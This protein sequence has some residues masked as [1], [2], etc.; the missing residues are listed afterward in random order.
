MTKSFSYNDFS[1]DVT[2]TAQNGWMFI[3]W[4]ENG[5]RFAGGFRTDIG[6]VNAAK[7]VIDEK[8]IEHLRKW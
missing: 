4:T 2:D 6:A 7:K 1:V 8:K 5:G 3:I